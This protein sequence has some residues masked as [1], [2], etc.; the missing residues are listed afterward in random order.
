MTTGW[1]TRRIIVTESTDPEG[2]TWT[3]KD[4]V[5]HAGEFLRVPDVEGA[6]TET[7]HA[8]SQFLALIDA[9]GAVCGGEAARDIEDAASNAEVNLRLEVITRLLAVATALEPDYGMFITAPGAAAAVTSPPP[10]PE[11]PEWAV[12]W[13]GR[14]VLISLAASFTCGLAVRSLVGRLA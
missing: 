3:A 9:A 12:R 2:Q 6:A 5:S 1:T 7:R 14:R 8:R 11:W 4:D 13:R 10:M